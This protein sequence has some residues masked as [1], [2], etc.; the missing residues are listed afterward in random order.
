M[1]DQTL[2]RA[3]NLRKN[4]TKTE[5]KLWQALRKKQLAGLRF[6]K[7]VP[8]G[9]YIADFICYEK[10]LII[11]L[12]GGQHSENRAY[13]EKRTIWL[14]DQGFRVIRFWNNDVMNDINAVASVILDLC[15]EYK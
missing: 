11:E 7:Q 4:L 15:S 12:D 3:R 2:R 10:R 14:E 9:S 6:R 8:I 13:D 1:Y 5:Q